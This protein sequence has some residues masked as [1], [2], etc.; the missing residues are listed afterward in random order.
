YVGNVTDT[1]GCTAAVSETI[2][3][4]TILSVSSNVVD[5]SSSSAT[6]GSITLI[7]SGGT[8]PYSYL[9]ST[10]DTTSTRTGLAAGSYCGTITDNH[11]K[12]IQKA[13]HPLKGFFY[14]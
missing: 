4:P 5:A 11:P 10:G 14:F 9:W 8:P 2:T 12:N 7:T 3:Q 6:D 1:N 13:L